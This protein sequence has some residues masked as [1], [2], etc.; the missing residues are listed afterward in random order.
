MKNNLLVL[1]AI[2]LFCFLAITCQKNNNSNPSSGGGN[3]G[4]GPAKTGGTATDTIFFNGDAS[5]GAANVWKDIDIQGT[6]VL[7]DTIDELGDTVWEMI[8]P[9][10]SHRTEGHG[11]KNFLAAEGDDIYIGWSS[12]LL[13]PLDT[14]TFAIFQWKSYPTTGALQNHPIMLRTTNGNLVLNDYLVGDIEHEDWST[15][16][17]LGAWMSFVVRLKVSRNPGIGFMEFSYN[18]VLQK[19]NNDSTRIYCRTLDADSCDPKW[20]AYGGDGG[21]I[22]HYVNKIRIASDYAGATH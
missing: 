6:G 21:N 15:P 11:A 16:L 17:T 22:V 20:G 10:G 7:K 19:L 9:V 1:T 4:G 8:K 18:G 2:A 5:R 13:M 14:N 3:A 12:K